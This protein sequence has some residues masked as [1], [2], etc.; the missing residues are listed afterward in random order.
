MYLLLPLNPFLLRHPQL[1]WFPISISDN[2]I[3]IEYLCA[4]W[5]LNP[6]DSDSSLMTGL[7]PVN[8]NDLT[9][10]EFIYKEKHAESKLRNLLI[11][12]WNVA[13]GE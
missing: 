11:I 8:T 6:N 3:R 10:S 5:W 12:L 9:T 7:T 2:V 13:G 4:L 1:S